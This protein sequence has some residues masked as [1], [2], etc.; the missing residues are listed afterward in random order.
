MMDEQG[1]GIEMLGER[2][3]PCGPRKRTVSRDVA[4]AGST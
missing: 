4:A 2:A 3:R 1:E